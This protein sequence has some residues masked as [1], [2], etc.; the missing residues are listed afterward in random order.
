MR[1]DYLIFQTRAKYLSVGKQ[2]KAYEDQKYEEWRDRVDQALPVLLKKNLIIKPT[3]AQQQQLQQ[4]QQQQ[5][6]EEGQDDPGT[7]FPHFITSTPL[8][9]LL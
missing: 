8:S 4:M 9:L 7:N 1:D 6:A 5:A 3:Q 2:M